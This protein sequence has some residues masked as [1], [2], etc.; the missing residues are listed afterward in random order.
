MTYETYEQPIVLRWGSL[1]EFLSL[2]IPQRDETPLG[3]IT[4]A[5][6]WR[7]QKL[8]E[9]IDSDSTGARLNLG[10][11]CKQNELYISA[12][13]ARRLFKAC[14]GIGIKEYAKKRRLNAAAQQLLK[15]DEPVKAIAMDAGYRHVRNFTRC[16]LKQFHVGPLDFRK[17]GRQKNTAA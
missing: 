12:R 6:D 15:T 16:F 4:V 7:V 9:L 1:S 13:Q 11:I 5:E 8:K 3:L 10:E 2:L 17:I 14:T